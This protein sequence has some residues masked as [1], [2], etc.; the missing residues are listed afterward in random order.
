MTY[1]IV[2]GL[3]KLSVLA[4]YRRILQG[5]PSRTLLILNWTIFGLVATNTLVNVFVAAFQ[6]HPIHDAFDSKIKG[7][8]INDSAFYIG[9]VITGIFTDS[10]VYFLSIPIVRPLQMD[11]K[12]KF[13]ILITLLIGI[14]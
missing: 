13:V 14:L 2:L 5:V 3:V 1:N 9:N 7:K 10:L 6:C 4:L 12:R 8:C 11:R